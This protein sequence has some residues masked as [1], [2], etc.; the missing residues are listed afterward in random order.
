MSDDSPIPKLD[1]RQARLVYDMLAVRALADVAQALHGAR[2]A[3]L[4]VKGV[5]LARWLY[6]DVRDRPYVDVDLLVSRAAFGRAAAVVRAKEWRVFY[7]ADEMGELSFM[8]GSVAVELHAEV[9]RI[10]LSRLTVD[11]VAARARPERETFP[12]EILHIDDVDHFLLLVLNVV[13]DGFTYANPHQP[14]DL[15][16]MLARI[17]PRLDEAVDRARAA[18]LLTA[19]R[20]TTDWMADTHASAAFAALRARLP[21]ADRRVFGTAVTLQRRLSRRRPERFAGPAGMLGLAL[22]SLTPDDPTLR[23]HGLT[24]VLRRGLRRKLGQ[25]PG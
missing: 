19:L 12:F 13:K 11:D 4:P 8:V 25:D 16:R 10:D 24:R 2:V 21:P 5:V 6:E 20:A 14:A 15:E 7:R 9:G 17:T 3:C 22:A 18:A 23:R 1:D